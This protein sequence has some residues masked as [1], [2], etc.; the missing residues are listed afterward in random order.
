MAKPEAVDEHVSTRV[1]TAP[2]VIS[3]IRIVLI[4]VFVWLLVSERDAWAITALAAAGV[5]DFLDGFLARRLGQ[6]TAL[7]RILDPAADR[8]LTVAVAVGLGIRGIVPWALIAVLLAR[9]AL[10]G[11]A[12]LWGRNR[13]APAPQVTF[14]GKAATAGLYVFL[15]L[16]YLAFERW[17]VVWQV[18][19]AGAVLSTAAYWLSGL[20]YVAAVR[21]SAQP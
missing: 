3:M 17:H 20:G 8:L 19:I 15:P 4:G 13:G 18:A 16:S 12:L 2:N 14:I 6:V 11:A 21:R 1:W 7:G 5:S 9:D 10:V